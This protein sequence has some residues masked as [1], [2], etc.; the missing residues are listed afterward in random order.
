MAKHTTRRV[1]EGS[2]HRVL[3]AV[4]L[5]IIAACNVAL[6]DF[7]FVHAS[8]THFGVGKNHEIDAEFFR[9]ISALDPRPA[10]VINTGD[11]CEI[12]SDEEYDL[13]REAIKHL[14]MPIYNAPGNHDVRWNPRGKEGFTLGV[15]Q[16]LYQSWDHENVHFVTLD[17]TVLLNH[18]GH[19]SQKQLDWLAEDLKKVGPEKPVVI[20]FHHW[21]GREAIQV[22]NE[23]ALLK[24]VE[25]YNVVLWLQGHGHSDIKW[26]IRGVPA[27]MQKGLYQGSYSVVTVTDEKMSVRRR[28]WAD[29]RRRANELVRDKSVPTTQQV[30]WEDVFTHIPL[31][32]RGK[33]AIAAATTRPAPAPSSTK[34]PAWEVNIHGEVQSRIAIDDGRLFVPSMG[35]DLVAIE[36]A[37]GREAF[38]V[39][40]GDSV[41][42]S[43]HA[44]DGMVYFGSADHHVYAADAKTGSVKWKQKTGGA[45]L[46]GPNVAGGVVCVGST[47]TK[48]YGLDAATGSVR[49]NVQGH[50]MYQSKVATDGQHFFVGGWDN[51]FRCI[52][53]ETGREIWALKLGKSARSNVF[54]AFSPAIASPTVGEG[55]VYVS[56]NDGILHGLEIATGKEI[57]RIDW[58]KMGYSSPLYRDGKIY[59]A[60]SDEGKVFCADAK[61]GSFIWEADAGSVI[62]DSSFCYGGGNV[63]IVTVSGTVNAFDAASGKR[64]WQHKLAPGHVL[65]S[66]AADDR[67]V[68]VGSMNGNITALPVK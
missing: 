41:Y 17:S 68:Y 11:V 6:A 16:P 30:E 53:A 39:T 22:D 61:T 5:W 60:L 35:G 9:E 58:Q 64:V 7:T 59:C 45:V 63:F 14:Q 1:F 29:Q 31:R 62:Y 66:P 65:A 56:T 36:V 50:N 49:W 3:A 52:D 26:S 57:W 27:M 8:D 2:W 46:A 20:A 10:F 13:Y 19:I 47:D 54:S 37:D 28:S 4:C 12:G 34:R 55:I 44:Q 18:W 21:I 67:C 42:S 40:T 51:R 48:I 38:R 25:P 32:P 23:L 24:V 43:P 15:G 33:T